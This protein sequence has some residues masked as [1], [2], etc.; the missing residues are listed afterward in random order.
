VRRNK[1]A[2]SSY[3]SFPAAN[4]IKRS[5]VLLPSTDIR[6]TLTETDA[7]AAHASVSKVDPFSETVVPCP[8][9]ILL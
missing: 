1:R 8:L 5:S 2:K 7:N 4:R 9:T 3:S 6:K